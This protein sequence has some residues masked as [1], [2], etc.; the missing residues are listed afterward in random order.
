MTTEHDRF[1]EPRVP[2]ILA[3]PH[4]PEHPER[5]DQRADMSGHR[6]GPQTPSQAE[7][8]QASRAQCT[9]GDHQGAE[10][11]AVNGTGRFTSTE[12]DGRE[13][14]RAHY[15]QHPGRDRRHQQC[16]GR[17]R[18]E[19]G[20]R[21]A[22]AAPAGSRHP[23]RSHHRRAG[24]GREQPGDHLSRGAP[25]CEGVHRVGQTRAGDRD[26]GQHRSGSEPAPALPCGSG[27]DVQRGQQCHQ[28]RQRGVLDRV[29]GPP[30]A[31]AKFVMGPPGTQHHGCEQQHGGQQPESSPPGP[32]DTAASGSD[33]QRLGRVEQRGM[34]VHR[35]VLEYR[36]E[37]TS[38]ERQ[39]AVEREGAGG[40]RDHRCGQRHAHSYLAAQL[41]GTEEQRAEHQRAPQ[42]QRSARACP[43]SCQTQRP[44]QLVTGVAGD[45]DQSQVDGHETGSQH[46]ERQPPCRDG[47]H[48]RP[49]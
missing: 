38:V 24:S 46:T 15:Q 33:H 31:P 11:G 29:P 7:D 12:P 10:Q 14:S 13:C 41:W 4:R 39:F 6:R 1:A 26:P 25:G 21:P 22:R 17:A 49:G 28:R 8:G 3:L 43:G 2:D 48:D 5:E 37:A 30:A 20:P 18:R 27:P 9:H 35:P 34:D 36:I 40:E 16:R 44:G 45:L 47:E 42:Q 23:Q 32:V 19:L